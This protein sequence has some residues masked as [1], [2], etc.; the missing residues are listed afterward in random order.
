[1]HQKTQLFIP[2]T[3]TAPAASNDKNTPH[4]SA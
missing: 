2:E 4:P 1:M 3:K